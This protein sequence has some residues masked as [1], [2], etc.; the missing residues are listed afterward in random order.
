MKKNHKQVTYKRYLIWTDNLSEGWSLD[1][2]TDDW[3]EAVKSRDFHLNNG[4]ATIITEYIPIV[5]KDGRTEKHNE[6][7]P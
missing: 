2:Q 3:D 4:W 7:N 1:E 5:V 6:A